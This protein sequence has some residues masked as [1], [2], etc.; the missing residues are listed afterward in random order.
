ML[1]FAV[2]FVTPR[3]HELIVRVPKP[4][5]PAVL[6]EVLP[7]WL[8]AEEDGT[9]APGCEVY[10]IPGL[11]ARLTRGQLILARPGLPGRI[12][13]PSPADGD[14]L[15]LMRLR[16]GGS[17]HRWGSAIYVASKDSYEDQIWFT[18][19]VGDIF[20]LVCDL[21]VTNTGS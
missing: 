8:A 1:P 2:R 10:G 15:P 6:R 18:G 17:A 3:P 5:L 7:A 16:Y 21:Y 20:D 13:I 12:I 19:T 4:Y 11:R 9:G 14:R